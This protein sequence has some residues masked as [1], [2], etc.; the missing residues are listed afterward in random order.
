MAVALG[1]VARRHKLEVRVIPRVDSTGPSVLVL[2]GR[3]T[4]RAK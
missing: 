4:Y 3:R 1:D 2:F